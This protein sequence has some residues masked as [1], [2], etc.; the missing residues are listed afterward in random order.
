MPPSLRILI[1]LRKRTA[2]AGKINFYATIVLGFSFSHRQKAMQNASRQKRQK[3]FIKLLFIK[4]I[5]A[6]SIHSP[7][8]NCCWKKENY[9]SHSL[10]GPN[11]MLHRETFEPSGRKRKTRRRERNFHFQAF[12]CLRLRNAMMKLI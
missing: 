4:H 6:R 11:E 3:G 12:L 1:S 7:S 9:E 10:S 2:M 8:L 5:H